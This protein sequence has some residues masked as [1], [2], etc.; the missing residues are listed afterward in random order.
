MKMQSQ[1][2][3]EPT[4]EVIT[5]PARA[6]RIR[7]G[8]AV[9]WIAYCLLV[10]FAVLYHEPWADEAE[11]WLM[12]RDLPLHRLLF[13]E[14]RYE[15]SPGLWH[16]L[17]WA[18]TRLHLPF[19]SLNFFAAAI[20]MI[21]AAYLIFRA[22]FPAPIRYAI[23]ASY[24][25]LYQY[26]V[27]ARPYV[28]IPLLV[29]IT[30]DLFS[31]A[32][33]KTYLFSAAL[34]VLA[35][36]SAHGC[37]MAIA[38]ACGYAL[39]LPRYWKALGP[40]G[41]RRQVIAAALFA[42]AL[43]LIFAEL[44]PP[45]D[46]MVPPS[47]HGIEQLSNGFNAAMLDWLPGSIAVA[48]IFGIWTWRRKN[49]AVYAIGLAGLLALYGFVH[50]WPQHIGLAY[51]MVIAALWQSWPRP[52]ER[53]NFRKF[54]RVAYYATIVSL[55]FVLVLQIYYSSVA[56]DH[57]YRL[58]YSG[59]RQAAGYLRGIL[60]R[61]Q[62][63]YGYDYGMTSVL[64]YF[65]H[66]IFPNESGFNGGVSYFH[67]SAP[68]LAA[69][70]NSFLSFRQTRPEYLLFACWYPQQATADNFLASKEGYVLEHVFPGRVIEK[71][72]FG[73]YQTYLLYRRSDLPGPVQP[74][75]TNGTQ[76]VTCT[77]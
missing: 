19:G 57:E 21:G 69:D 44:L 73:V 15:G 49:F 39:R 53:A 61:G 41:R 67:H 56:I 31:R 23:A 63:V 14:M 66:N 54:D 52:L 64:A 34:I 5:S 58:P 13:S 46:L 59:A 11:A 40:G 22:P 55:S 68:Y 25:I 3:L 32:Q 10:S 45:K 71:A 1:A 28:L 7:L 16:G 60:A 30:A 18:M 74:Q 38:F 9:A 4:I 50:G 17:L 51:V 76:Y 33:K 26:A 43:L 75:T 8:D 2:V 48:L 42:G 37:V 20:A 27:I 72:S 65:D 36:T 47:A 24:W 12:A 62:R 29:F 70:N 35:F 6:Q 77:P